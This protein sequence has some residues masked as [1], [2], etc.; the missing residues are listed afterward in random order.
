MAT[1]TYLSNP[2]V[3]I[4]AVDVSDQCSAATLTV[5]YDAL[6]TT[7]FGSSGR[8]YAAGLESVEVTLTLFNSYGASEIEATL[9]NIV[10]TTATLV[11]KP[12]SGAA[13]AD[14]P[15]YTITGAFLASIPPIQANVG[16]L[17]TVDITFTGGTWARATS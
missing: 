6:E 17:S 14:N 7:A 1:T 4:G 16:E 3:T 12:K 5:G 8:S 2:S 15:V 11:L 13:A 10:G 9:E